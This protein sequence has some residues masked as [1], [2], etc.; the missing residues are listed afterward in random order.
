MSMAKVVNRVRAA[1]VPIG[2]C[3]ALWLCPI[4][5]YKRKAE[6][7]LKHGGEHDGD[8]Q[9][10]EMHASHPSSEVCHV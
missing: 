3:G 4:S 9:A 2:A 7:E 1:S 5:H 10:I 6:K 8:R